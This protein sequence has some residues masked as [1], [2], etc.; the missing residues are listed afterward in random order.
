MQE[1]FRKL[2]IRFCSQ[3]NEK[4][5]EPLA[6]GGTSILCPSGRWAVSPGGAILDARLYRGD[7]VIY[8]KIWSR[9]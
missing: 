6:F 4:V 5:W 3:T 9:A 8:G 1:P 7:A 2:R